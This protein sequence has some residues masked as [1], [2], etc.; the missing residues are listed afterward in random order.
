MEV[1]AYSMIKVLPKTTLGRL[2]IFSFLSSPVFFWIGVSVMTTYYESVSSGDTMSQDLQARPL[3]V[4]SMLLGNLLG[5]LA[6]VFGVIGIV[7]KKERSFLVFLSTLLGGIFSF[8]ILLQLI[9]A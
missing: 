8:F 4:I 5:I 3:L 1:I 9:G 6:F 2:S 7:K